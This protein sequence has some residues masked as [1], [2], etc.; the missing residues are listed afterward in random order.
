MKDLNPDPKAVSVA[1]Q[2][3]EMLRP[4]GTILLGSRARGDHLEDSSD[5]DIILVGSQ[6]DVGPHQKRV[7]EKAQ[8][9][10]KEI[11][12]RTIKTQLLWMTPEEL[13]EDEQYLNSIST[14]A[15]LEGVIFSKHPERFRSRY[16]QAE[17]P[18]PKYKWN[19]YQHHLAEAKMQMTL[20]WMFLREDPGGESSLRRKLPENNV[21]RN[22]GRG[23]TEAKIKNNLS[24]RPSM[25]IEHAL[26]A[27]IAGT[28]KI[29]RAH[30]EMPA[31]DE[32]LGKITPQEDRK[33]KIALETYL[34]KTIPQG[35]SQ[36]EF[37]E[38]ADGDMTKLRRLAMR[39]KRRTG[40]NEAQV[41][42]N[43]KNHQ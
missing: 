5:I 22:I 2:V 21:L 40:K 19:T 36:K 25:A 28:G 20:A 41:Q 7:E 29:P 27:A 16:D 13:D 34:K 17:P 26:R 43:Q 33:T 10:S 30:A 39:L 38:T 15:L 4:L 31:L 35:M 9:I 6:P 18:P 32:A 24:A 1:K 12:G 42:Q 8:E 11:Y 23:A 3:H 37:I 14:Q